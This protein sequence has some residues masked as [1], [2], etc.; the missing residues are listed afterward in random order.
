LRK[1]AQQIPHSGKKIASA[2]GYHQHHQD[3]HVDKIVA[4]ILKNLNTSEV[5]KYWMS[6]FGRM[7]WLFWQKIVVYLLINH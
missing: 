4:I 1:L 3:I 5:L 6:L 7:F 2:T